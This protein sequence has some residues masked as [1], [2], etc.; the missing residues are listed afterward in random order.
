ML[1]RRISLL[2]T[3]RLSNSIVKT[4]TKTFGIISGT[5]KKETNAKMVEINYQ[6]DNKTLL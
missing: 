6:D 4:Q 1:F 2:K 3:P 5:Y